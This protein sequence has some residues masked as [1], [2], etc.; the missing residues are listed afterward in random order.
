MHGDVRLGGV[1]WTAF[2]FFLIVGALLALF[3][4]VDATRR[5]IRNG[6]SSRGLWFYLL[7][8]GVYLG[9]LLLAQL[10]PVFPLGLGAVAS[11][12]TPF[13]I[14]IGV[15]YLLKVVYPKPNAGSPEPSEDVAARS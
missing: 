1:V 8:E 6:H 11:L 12:L 7:F 13:A 10:T 9:V 15:A 5:S 3:V 2:A 14:G 4:V